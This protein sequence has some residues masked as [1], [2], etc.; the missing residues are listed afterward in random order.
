MSASRAAA[1]QAFD[2]ETRVALLEG[3]IDEFELT[4]NALRSEL[5]GIRRVLVGLLVSVT[6]ACILLAINIAVV[7]GGR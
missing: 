3:D 7:G 2:Q 1:R 6:T 5:G 4:M